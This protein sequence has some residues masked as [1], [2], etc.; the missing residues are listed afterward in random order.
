MSKEI[1]GVVLD[2]ASLSS[3]PTL[4]STSIQNTIKI[5]HRSAIEDRK[6]DMTGVVLVGTDE[7]PGPLAFQNVSL[8]GDFKGSLGRLSE[9]QRVLKECEAGG[10]FSTVSGDL[11]DGVIQCADAMIEAMNGGK[12][13]A[14][15]VYIF[16]NEEGLSR[17]S[18]GEDGEE[19]CKEVHERLERE[20]VEVLFVGLDQDTKVPF[21]EPLDARLF[22]ADFHFPLKRT[23]PS[24]IYKG[25]LTIGTSFS[26]NVKVF[27]KTQV[28]GLPRGKWTGG[29]QRVTGYYTEAGE[30]VGEERK[31]KAYKYGPDRV[32]FSLVDQA[33][34]KS[35]GGG[36]KGLSLIGF[37]QR[38][39][40]DRS[41]FLGTV[42]VMTPDPDCQG[43]DRVLQ[44][45]VEAMREKRR[46]GVARFC[47][48]DSADPKLLYL[49][50]SDTGNHLLMVGAPF[51]EDRRKWTFPPLKVVADRV[52]AM[53]GLVD[54]LSQDDQLL[55]PVNPTIQH[56]WTAVRHRAVE[57]TTCMELPA[58]STDLLKNMTN[59]IILSDQPRIAELTGQL[60]R[61][62]PVN[63][64]DS[65]LATWHHPTSSETH[66]R[67]WT[68]PSTDDHQNDKDTSNQPPIDST[69]AHFNR[70]VNDSTEDRVPEAML[71]LMSLIPAMPLPDACR[72]LSRL[73]QVAVQFSHSL[74]YN[75]FISEMKRVAKSGD[76]GARALFERA[77]GE[78]GLTLV[79]EAEDVESAVSPVEALEFAR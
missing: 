14:V 26:V 74:R 53:D 18:E 76:G 16:T 34:S 23:R 27:N 54:L 13:G 55:V 77:V 5:L 49:I 45:L 79:S 39:Q 36:G 24:T 48:A 69:L 12:F 62:L 68:K 15:I 8:L 28:V 70:L 73:R 46:V 33:M 38:S 43:S 58:M 4:L 61:A 2:G 40:L 65:S 21:G 47:R 32:P 30:L 25:P 41:S 75:A 29:G 71:F 60:Q 9:W 37:G 66:S 11:L 22:D 42:S 35:D 52:Q 1:V 51:A 20:G 78:M 56:L 19:G 64:T 3:H 59:I 67:F 7:W 72:A 50:P 10:V 63:Q 31:V 57:P 17:M 6:S 44:C